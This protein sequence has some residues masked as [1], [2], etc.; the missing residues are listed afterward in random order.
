[1]QTELLQEFIVVANLLNYRK[2][3]EQLH[4][5]QS[6]LSKHITTLEREVGCQLLD[7]TGNT[8][9]TPKGQRF[10]VYAQ[11][12]LE[13]LDEAIAEC[14]TASDAPTP[15]RVQW[16]GDESACFERV[17]LS[18]ETPFI[19]AK[20]D[21]ETPIME[22]LD[23]G[24]ADVVIVYD[25]I[26]QPGILLESIGFERLAL[27][28]SR[29]HPLAKKSSLSKNDLLGAEIVLAYGNVFN[30]VKNAIE[31]SVGNDVDLR[32]I[33]EPA[34]HDILDVPYLNLDSRIVVGFRDVIEDICAKQAN[35]VMFD[36]LDGNL[37]LTEEFIAYRADN[38]NPNVHA[39]AKELR[40]IVE[41]G[42]E[43]PEDAENAL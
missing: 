1:M 31:K 37:I 24:V 9:L 10:Y 21:Y 5:T 6:A 22:A 25:D 28:T 7:R 32:F 4:I 13:T 42:K 23:P 30:H 43:S 19:R 3:S 29:R 27:L 36:T 2:A 35:F 8:H 16:G 20:A 40:A 14:R 33:R 15:V 17:L 12:I 18:I 11:R 41:Q 26:D 38:P 34:L 39:F